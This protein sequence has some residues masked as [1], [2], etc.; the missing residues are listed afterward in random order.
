L[1]ASSERST[2]SGARPQE[3][4]EDPLEAQFRHH[5]GK[6]S[7]QATVFFGGTIFTL[8]IGY[9]FKIY[10]A[11]S[12]GAEQ[13]GLYAL[14]MRIIGFFSLFV[15]LGLPISASRFI[16]TWSTEQPER[17]K[18]FWQRGLALTT[19]TAGA[20]AVSLFFLRH[21][22]ADL[23]NEPELG[24]ILPLFTLL[25][26]VSALSTFLS[27]YLRGHQRV[28]S[29][30][31][32]GKFVQVPAKIV[33][34]VA[35]FTVGL[36]LSG[37]IAAEIASALLAGLLLFTLGKRLTPGITTRMPLPMGRDVTVFAASMIGMASLGF[38]SGQ[39]DQLLVGY[40]L[41]ASRVG[42]YSVVVVTGAFIPMVLTS[43]NSI[44][45]PI[46]ARLHSKGEHALLERLFQTTTKWCLGLT[47]PLV[48]VLVIFAP[49]MMRIFG[50]DFVSG[51]PALA[52]IALAQLINVAA[53]SA[54]TLLVM[55]GNQRWE[56]IIAAVTALITVSLDVMLIPKWGVVGAAAAMAVGITVSN[57][58]RAAM[59]SRI[60]NLV[61]Y[62]KRALRLTLPAMSSLATVAIVHAASNGMDW[63]Y[64]QG[65]LIALPLAYFT[66]I[67]VSTISSLDDDDR[68][69]IRA[70]LRNI[71]RVIDSHR[72]R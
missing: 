2:A 58:S 33:L 1:P 61:P 7:R 50:P 64:W 68:L 37:Y 6:V 19:A 26:P 66:F 4:L 55:S 23:F 43:L 22:L 40:F 69:I 71:R 24:P 12:L 21:L 11:R 54:G 44:F 35:L 65:P 72:A 32:I 57:V 38:L 16:S 3:H 25:L 18:A 45:G 9:I 60:M 56:I 13:L 34:T 48:I 46:I 15:S 27:G 70:G 52:I 62:N 42:I 67:G 59:V 28:T 5:A 51:W 39:A 49:A 47:F 41:D 30:A 63:H 53:G 29:S 10:V 17:V 36:G 8:V 20:S 14:G 31:I